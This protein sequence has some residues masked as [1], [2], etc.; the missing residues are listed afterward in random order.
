MSAFQLEWFIQVRTPGLQSRDSRSR[1]G[2]L[3]YSKSPLVVVGPKENFHAC[4][5]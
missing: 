5:R 1:A 4:F 3:V 2:A